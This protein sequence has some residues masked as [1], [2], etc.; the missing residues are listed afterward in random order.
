MHELIPK[1]F[2]STLCPDFISLFP[3]IISEKYHKEMY[4]NCSEYIGKILFKSND[5]YKEKNIKIE[6][7]KK[8]TLFKINNKEILKVI[9]INEYEYVT[10]SRDLFATIKIYGDFIY[11]N[12]CITVIENVSNVMKII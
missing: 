10:Y 1:K 6:R 2:L 12:N 3:K 8:L 7:K 4:E 5:K 9:K 11:V